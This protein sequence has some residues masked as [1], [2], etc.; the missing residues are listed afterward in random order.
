MSWSMVW[1]EG[2]REAG[3]GCAG[4]CKPQ[5][6]FLVLRALTCYCRVFGMW[7]RGGGRGHLFR[8]ALWT[9]AKGGQNG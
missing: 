4:S 6:A 1:D 7:G 5:A 2:R 3:P 8:F 9:E